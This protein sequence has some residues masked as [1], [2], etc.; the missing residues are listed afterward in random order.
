MSSVRFVGLDVHKAT[1]VAAVAEAGSGAAEALGSWPWDEARVLKELNGPRRLCPRV[2][3]GEIELLRA[4]GMALTAAAGTLMPLED[5]QAAFGARSKM[6]VTGEFVEALLGP[7]R[8]PRGEAEAL[9]WLVENVIGSGNKRQAARWLAACVGSLPF[10]KD[11]RYGP[12]S[13][14]MRLAM[15]GQLQRAVGRAGL[16]EEDLRP[17]S[18]KLGELGG[19]V[20]ADAKLTLA[21]AKA[22]APAVHRLT[23]LLRLAIGD[24]GPTGPAADRARSEALKLL[25]SDDTRAELAK[26]PDALN[27]VRELVQQAGLAA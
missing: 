9:I 16:V 12:D 18:G 11:M 23:L 4:L 1:V 8:S 21:L 2:P 13:P 26:T 3:E 20:E 15:L 22:T 17:I 6:L 10:E 24:A 7:D 5:V 19:L 14:A 27:R 25:R